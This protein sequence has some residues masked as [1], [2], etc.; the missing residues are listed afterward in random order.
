MAEG[1]EE[2]RAA[3]GQNVGNHLRPHEQPVDRRSFML[4]RRIAIG[5]AA[6]NC[7]FKTVTG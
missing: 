2:C 3:A 1:I 6:Y 7:V 4:A 5:Y